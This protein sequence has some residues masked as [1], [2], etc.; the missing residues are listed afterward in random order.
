VDKSPETSRQ[1]QGSLADVLGAMPA[2]WTRLIDEHVP[3]PTGR[4]CRACTTAGTGSPG[5][6]WPC[7]IRDIAESARARYLARR[8]ESGPLG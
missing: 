4:R 8:T 2:L 5:A 1:A 3:D 6:A 7:Q